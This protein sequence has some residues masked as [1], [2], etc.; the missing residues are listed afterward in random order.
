[1]GLYIKQPV[2]NMPAELSCHA[3]LRSL[4]KNT[5]HKYI[6]YL[7]AYTYTCVCIYVLTTEIIIISLLFRTPYHLQLII[8]LPFVLFLF[9]L[10]PIGLGRRE[11]L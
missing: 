8:F 5:V 1:M 11:E 2:A 9:M 7:N 3:M 4:E 10:L 6:Q